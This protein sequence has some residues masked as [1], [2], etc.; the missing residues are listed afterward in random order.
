MKKF[1]KK[2]IEKIDLLEDLKSCKSHP[3][4]SLLAQFIRT[5]YRLKSPE[6]SYR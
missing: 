4:L 5:Q 1:I 2:V 3:L 6:L